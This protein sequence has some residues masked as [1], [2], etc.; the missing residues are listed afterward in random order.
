MWC[1]STPFRKGLTSAEFEVRYYSLSSLRDSR[2]NGVI[3][4]NGGSRI[5]LIERRLQV[6]RRERN[7]CRQ[8]PDGKS[9]ESAI[10]NIGMKPGQGQKESPDK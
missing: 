6:E 3:K 5:F 2:A 9:E 4:S 10:E 1:L 7:I 8:Q